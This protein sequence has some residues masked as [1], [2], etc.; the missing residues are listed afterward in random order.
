MKVI[1]SGA[2]GFIGSHVVEKLVRSGVNVTAMSAYNFENRTGWLSTLE[3]D[4]RDSIEVVVCDLR[5]SSAIYKAVA[6]HDAVMHLGALIGIPYSYH[7]PDSYIQVNTQGTL[8]L[9]E[10][11]RAHEIRRFVH[12]STSEVYGSAQKTPMDEEH[13]LFPQSPYAASKAAADHLAQAYFLSFGLPVVTIRPFNTFGPRQSNRA[14]IPT[15]INQFI[16]NDEN[17]KIGNLES[18]RDFTFVSD[19]ANGMIAGLLTEG[20]EGELFN[21]GTGFDFSIMKIYELL[22]E[23]SGKK[24]EIQQETSRIRPKNSEV[25]VLLSDNSK[26]Q[27]VL[28]WIPEFAGNEGF[29][30]ALM[31]TYDWYSR[32]SVNDHSA[33]NFVM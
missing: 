13:R 1:V 23:I 18:T 33:N 31:R 19:T 2:E 15:L 10:A 32:N 21:L 12:I 24:L 27:K 6:G 16:S 20:V 5:D 17:I 26:A 3:S 25:N 29:K 7:A 14:V 9:L 11:S 22:C 30:A 4:I 8:N 28:Q